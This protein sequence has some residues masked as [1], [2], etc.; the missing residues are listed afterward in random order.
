MQ[1]IGKYNKN[2]YVVPN[3]PEKYLALSW[4]FNYVFKDSFQF[5]PTSLAALAE[6]LRKDAG[7]HGFKFL[8]CQFRGEAIP[9]FLRM[10][11]YPYEYMNSF[12]KFEKKSSLLVTRS[13]VL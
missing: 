13:K 1:A 10:G 6:N 3:T 11:I 7:E 2:I 4:G 5:L 8:C 12:D 9:L